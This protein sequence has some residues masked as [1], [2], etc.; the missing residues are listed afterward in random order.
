MKTTSTRRRPARCWSSSSSPFISAD[1]SQPQPT[2][3]ADIIAFCRERLAGYKCPRTI[4]FAEAL[5]R[6]ASGK[7]LKRDLRNPYWAER[8]RA[9]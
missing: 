6:N 5:P 2:D 8:D 9:I 7:L 3:E 1:P 4:Q